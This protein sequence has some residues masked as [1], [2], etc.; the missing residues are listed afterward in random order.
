MEILD[1]MY[2]GEEEQGVWLPVCSDEMCDDR[3]WNMHHVQL[4]L[5]DGRL[6]MLMNRKG[7]AKRIYFESPE[8]RWKWLGHRKRSAMFYESKERE[9]ADHAGVPYAPDVKKRGKRGDWL[10]TLL[11]IGELLVL[12]FAILGLKDRAQ[13]FLGT[14]EYGRKE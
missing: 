10:G 1:Y 13:W 3:H 4:R 7:P 11:F 9:L 8:E 6:K 2:L 5:C 14:G 12:P